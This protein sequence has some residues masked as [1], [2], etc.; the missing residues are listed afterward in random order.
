MNFEK[1]DKINVLG[2]LT[3]IKTKLIYYQKVQVNEDI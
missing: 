2:V 1:I 3:R